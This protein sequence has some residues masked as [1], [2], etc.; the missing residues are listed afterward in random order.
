MRIVTRNGMAGHPVVSTP[1]QSKPATL[2]FERSPNL[3]LVCE[4]F[5]L[6]LENPIKSFLVLLDCRL[7]RK[8]FLLVIQNGRLMAEDRLVIR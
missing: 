4:D 8:D 5:F 7:I 2:L 1:G 6:I 3:L